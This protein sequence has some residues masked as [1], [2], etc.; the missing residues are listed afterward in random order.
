MSKSKVKEKESKQI[1]VSKYLIPKELPKP[2]RIREP[3][4]IYDAL[5]KK[6]QSMPDGAYLIQIP[7]KDNP[8]EFIKMKS[9]YPLLDRRIRDT[10]NIWL[11]V[12][13][14]LLYICKGKN[15]PVRKYR[16]KQ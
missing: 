6:I 7:K 11:S 10:P 5:I 16:K 9:L 13:S 1:D 3:H 15:K 12:R 14:G 2:K 8:R 4:P